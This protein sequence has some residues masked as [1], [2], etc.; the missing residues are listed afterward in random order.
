MRV[1]NII[2]EPVKQ[3]YKYGVYSSLAVVGVSLSAF[4][5]WS[6]TC[7]GGAVYDWASKVV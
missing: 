3:A 7:M 6:F 1:E 2:T 5:L 4:I